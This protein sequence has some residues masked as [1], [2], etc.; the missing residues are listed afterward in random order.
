MSND[1]YILG[2]QTE[3]SWSLEQIR[4]LSE[5]VAALKAQLREAVRLLTIP[6]KGMTQD[7]YLRFAKDRDALLAQH[8]A[9]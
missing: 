3:A 9:D 4:C 8:A 7:D 1:P 6:A 2:L 5:E